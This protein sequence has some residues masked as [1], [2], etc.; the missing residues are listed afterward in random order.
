M[1]R[2]KM[3]NGIYSL[4]CP[5][6]CVCVFQILVRPITSLYMVGLKD[7]L[8]QMIIKTRRCVAC[9]NHVAK[10]K[11]KVTIAPKVLTF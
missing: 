5:C 1:P 8:E 9:K 7:N 6:V 4:P 2:H 11:V 10:S 3:A